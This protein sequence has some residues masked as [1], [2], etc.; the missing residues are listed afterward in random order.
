MNPRVLLSLT[1]AAASLVMVSCPNPTIDA[2]N[3]PPPRTSADFSGGQEGRGDWGDWGDWGDRGERRGPM[4]SDLSI[5]VNKIR[6]LSPRF[7]KGV[8]ISMLA[9]IEASGG[10]FYQED[11][12]ARDALEILRDHGVNWVRLRIWNNPVFPPGTTSYH[13]TPVGPGP[14]GGG[15]NDETVVRGLARRAKALGMRV[16]LDFHYSD[17]WADPGKQDTPAAWRSL[18][19]AQLEQAVYDYTKQ[20][21]RDMRSDGAAPDLVEIGNEINNGMLWPIGQRSGAKT[22][23]AGYGELNRLLNAGAKAVRDTSRFTKIMIHI[24]SDSGLSGAQAFFDNVDPVV[25]YDC[26]G[27]SYYP[28]WHGSLADLQ[29]IMN[30]L[31]ARYHK[32]VIIAETA[33]AFTSA[34]GD[35]QGNS[36]SGTDPISGGFEVSVQGQAT[37]MRNIMEAVSKVPRDRGLGVFYWEPDWIPVPGAGWITGQGDG[38]E[39]QAWWDFDGK[40][41]ESMWTYRLVSESPG[42]KVPTTIASI[43]PTAVQTTV[44]VAPVLPATVVA[45]FSDASYRPVPVTWNAIDPSQYASVGSFMVSGTVAGTS[46]TATA[47]VSVVEINYAVNG[48]FET[49]SMTPWTTSAMSGGSSV[50]AFGV[51]NSSPSGNTRT[52]SYVGSYWYGSAYTFDVHQTVTGLAAGTY[53]LRAWVMGDGA[54]TSLDI[55]AD[56][57]AKITAAVTNTGW[58]Q[59]HPYTIPGITVG[60]SGQLV[61]G[62]EGDM[63]GGDW[64]KLD[65]IVLTRQ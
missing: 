55:Y 51:E 27:L 52:G 4:P 15:N 13:G 57:G 2:N 6:G 61:I 10:R 49:G 24:A 48:G 39:N 20:V 32:P 58:R 44:G 17:F 64:G 43:T 12:T 18:T 30:T 16:Y 7:M 1:A 41:L 62:F 35:A 54:P 22:D 59:W 60:A 28:Y 19:A 47:N 14:A 29:T 50:S 3:A 46:L 26:I 34:N 63:S 65:D 38:W 56:N 53:T 21:L 42:R 45:F 37:A 23:P 8:D 33:Y 11:G 5:T 40:P 9:Q 31:T 25:D 36:W